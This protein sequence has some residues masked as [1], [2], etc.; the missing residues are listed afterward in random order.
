MLKKIIAG[1]CAAVTVL[2]CAAFCAVDAAREL[3]GPLFYHHYITYN[4][5]AAYRNIESENPEYRNMILTN[6]SDTPDGAAWIG[7]AAAVNT[8]H[9]LDIL[10]ATMDL[11]E[12]GTYTLERNYASPVSSYFK[13]TN[14]DNYAN[15]ISDNRFKMGITPLAFYPED[16]KTLAE[17]ITEPITVETL[18][19]TYMYNRETFTEEIPVGKITLYSGDFPQERGISA[20][21]YGIG[22]F[23]SGGGNIDYMDR[24]SLHTELSPGYQF[25]SWEVP[26]REEI[27]D[28]ISIEP[29]YSENSVQ[30]S[31]T[32]NYDGHGLHYFQIDPVLVVSDAAGNQ[33]TTYSD[34]TVCTCT[35]EPEN[36]L[37]ELEQRKGGAL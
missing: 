22:A 33:I 20:D 3:D 4:V 30:L 15:P 21:E 10:S 12:L 23:G 28:L 9:V 7:I 35:H 2:S 37:T 29:F 11:G 8:R 5:K 16:L 1:V 24:F 34:V 32:V 36:V 17:S 6:G 31:I 14:V 26:Y 25:S 13:L 18:T 19:V 27:G